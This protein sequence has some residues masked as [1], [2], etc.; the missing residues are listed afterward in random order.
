MPH[1]RM[2][3]VLPT[4]FISRACIPSTWGT[5]EKKNEWTKKNIF[6]RSQS[7]TQTELQ[8]K[9]IFDAILWCGR[10]NIEQRNEYC[11]M[12]MW[13]VDDVFLLFLLVFHFFLMRVCACHHLLCCSFFRRCF[14]IWSKLC[15]RFWHVKLN[16]GEIVETKGRKKKHTDTLSQC[17][18][19]DLKAAF[20]SSGCH[21]INQ[22]TAWME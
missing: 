12:F 8:T 20:T 18:Q 6:E 5:Q 10:K 11:Y 4:L 3:I 1:L 21:Q 22:V 17:E 9:R 14:S 7:W 16:L 19:F 2:E 13:C 15:A